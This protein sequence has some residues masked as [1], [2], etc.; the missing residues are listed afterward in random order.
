[1][2]GKQYSFRGRDRCSLYRYSF[3]ILWSSVIF[4]NNQYSKS[5]KLLAKKIKKGESAMKKIILILTLFIA[6]ITNAQQNV[7]K[8]NPLGLV[9]GIANAGYERV[10][11]NKQ[12][13]TFSSNYFKFDEIKGFGIGAGY[14]IYLTNDNAPDGLHIGPGM[15]VSF[16]SDNE[17][18]ATLL[19]A[20]ATG[21]YQWI[22]WKHFA[23]DLTASGY[24]LTTTKFKDFKEFNYSFGIAIG[25]AW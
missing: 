9:F 11:D 6:T 24:Y 2:N 25:Y 21:G 22:L 14:N 15:G 13:F 20:N 5:E 16:L 23:I 12:S 7:V 8:V 10:I 3:T 4:I 17:V 1:L 18:S 19:N